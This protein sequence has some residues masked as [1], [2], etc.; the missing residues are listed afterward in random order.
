MMN[1]D[2]ASSGEFLRSEER[3][4]AFKNPPD[5]IT[6][7]TASHCLHARINFLLRTTEM[8]HIHLSLLRCRLCISLHF[9]STQTANMKFTAL[10]VLVIV[11]V[12][13]MAQAYHCP[14]FSHTYPCARASQTQEW[15]L[16]ETDAMRK[17]SSNVDVP[18]RR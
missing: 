12:S 9:G 3:V 6:S 7:L 8:T 18:A 11:I 10:V 2:S 14:D 15:D 5:P 17:E 1:E 16:V 4:N 13:E